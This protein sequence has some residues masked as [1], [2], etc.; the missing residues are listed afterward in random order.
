[1]S[2]KDEIKK[3]E[4]A[5]DYVLSRAS[6]GKSMGD[7]LREFAQK[8]PDKAP[9]P[10]MVEQSI[11]NMEKIEQTLQNLSANTKRM[12]EAKIRHEQ[13]GQELAARANMSEDERFKNLFGRTKSELMGGSQ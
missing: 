13:R 8:F 2:W 7:A 6:S 11:K 9:P 10:E 4:T 5:R 1:M 3:E 12:E